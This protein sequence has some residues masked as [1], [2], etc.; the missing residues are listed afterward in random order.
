[1]VIDSYRWLWMDIDEWSYLMY[2]NYIKVIDG[3]RQNRS[4]ITRHSS[5]VFGNN[6]FLYLRYEWWI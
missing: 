1:M 5:S 3:Y 2:K 4:Y 6:S